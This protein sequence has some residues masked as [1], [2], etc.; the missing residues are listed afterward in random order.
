MMMALASSGPLPSIL[1]PGG[2]TLLPEAGEDA[3]KVQSIGARFAQQQITLEYAAG[4]WL[5]RLR[6]A[7]R[8]LPVSGHGCNVASSGRGPRTVAAPRGTGALRPTH[9]ARCGRAFG[10]RDPAHDS[11][12]HGNRRRAHG[13]R[14]PECHGA[15]RSLWR[16]DQPAAARSGHRPRGR[17]CER[18][19]AADWAAINREVP[20]L[21]D[22][23]PNGPNNFAT[24]QV[25]LAGGVPEVMLHLRRAGL[26][27]CQVRTVTGETLDENLNWWEQ[28]ERRH[29]LKERLAYPR[30][31]RC[32][33]R[34]SLTGSGASAGTDIDGLL[35]D[36]Q[37]RA[38]RERHQEHFHR[39]FSHRREQCLPSCWTGSGFHN[40]GGSH[41]RHQARCRDPRR[42]DCPDLRRTR[43]SR[44]AG[45]LSDHRRSEEPSLLQ[46][47]RRAYRRTLQRC[48]DRSM[49]RPHLAR[50]LWP[51][52]QSAVCEMEILSRSSSTGTRCTARL[53][54]S[55]KERSGSPRRKVGGGSRPGRLGMILL[56]ILLCQTIPVSGQRSCRQAEGFGAV[57]L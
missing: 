5:P 49:H 23:L 15:P 20:R 18:P 14:D 51:E 8:R 4:D 33:R 41:R 9:M 17:D 24:V 56:P 30:R 57:R 52:A 39:F 35:S 13:R 48:V 2:V 21:V 7:R 50:K 55:A 42:C 36:R 12:R 16:I 38:R 25:F 45:D 53:I 31:H 6:H 37:S 19:T 3:G 22:A 28:S 46:T 34:D 43:R 40:R 27:D 26:L 47:C 1:I 32:R 29:A 54:S 10:A 11:A 44:H